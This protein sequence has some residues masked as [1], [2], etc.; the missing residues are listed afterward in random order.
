VCGPTGPNTG[1]DTR[2]CQVTKTRGSTGPNTGP[3]TR[4]CQVTETCGSTGPNTGPDTRSC[5]VTET[6]GPT[7]PN[8]GPDT[9]SC[10]VTETCGPTGP[11]RGPDTRSCQVTGSLHSPRHPLDRLGVPVIECLVLGR[12]A[13]SPATLPTEPSW[14]LKKQTERG[15]ERREGQGRE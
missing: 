9:R 5:Q 12:E 6:R 7:G 14:L 4:S 13:A 1:P 8:T 2:S 15:R 3:D 10:Q 11:N